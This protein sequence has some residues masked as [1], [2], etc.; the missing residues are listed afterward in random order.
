MSAVLS[1]GIKNVAVSGNTKAE[2]LQ[3]FNDALNANPVDI[4][5]E[6]ATPIRTPIDLPNFGS[7]QTEPGGTMTFDN[8]FMMS[9]PS[10]VEHSG[11][12]TIIQSPS[13]GDISFDGDITELVRG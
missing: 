11:R 3:A 10:V 5:Y 13:G 6:I 8:Q 12:N 9:V 4:V 1:L 2:Y 7:F